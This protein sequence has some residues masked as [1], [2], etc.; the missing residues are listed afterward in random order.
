[1]SAAWDA[2]IASRLERLKD[3]QAELHDW[4][5]VER[6]ADAVLED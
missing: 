3:G 6:E 5:D 1:V 4:D 2:E